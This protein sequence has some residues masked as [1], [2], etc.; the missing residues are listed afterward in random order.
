ME[1]RWRSSIN[2]HVTTEKLEAA[3][4]I[5]S[6]VSIGVRSHGAG[7]QANGLPLTGRSTIWQKRTCSQ[8]NTSGM[9]GLGASP[10]IM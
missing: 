3:F 2:V 1:R 8:R 10:T 5:S 9:V 6:T 7:E 4:A